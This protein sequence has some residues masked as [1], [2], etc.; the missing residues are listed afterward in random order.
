[1][2]QRQGPH[3]FTTYELE[4]KIHSDKLCC[5]F[6][7]NTTNYSGKQKQKMTL[8]VTLICLNTDLY[9]KGTHIGAAGLPLPLTFNT[10]KITAQL[11]LL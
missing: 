8:K 7:Y 5:S 9:N 2:K 11:I 6:R 4:S 10:G 1:M 3:H